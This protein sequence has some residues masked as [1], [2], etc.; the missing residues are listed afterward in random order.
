LKIRDV[1][2]VLCVL[3]ALPIFVVIGFYLPLMWGIPI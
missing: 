1:S 2:I 3:L